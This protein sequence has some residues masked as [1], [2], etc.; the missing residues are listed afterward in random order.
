MVQIAHVAI[1]DDWEAA[2][3]FGEYEV[4]TLGVSLDDAGFVHAVE[5]T[6]VRRVLNERYAN[7]RYDLLLVILETDALAT[8]GLEV[9]E[10]SPGHFRVFGAIQTHGDAVV[11][12]LSI[13]RVGGDFVLPDLSRYGLTVTQ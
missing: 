8:Y 13:G 9:T 10:Q 1:I 7:V 11:A 3:R 6:G 12:V 5:L 2:V 4:S